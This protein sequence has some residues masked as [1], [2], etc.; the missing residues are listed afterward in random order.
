[1]LIELL[2]LMNRIRDLEFPWNFHCNR[3]RYA[4]QLFNPFLGDFIPVFVEC[5]TEVC[6]EDVGLFAFGPA[7][8]M[9]GAVVA[10]QETWETV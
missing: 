10:V 7:D 6:F 2:I 4:Q 1:M 3:P 9:D 8:A 5:G